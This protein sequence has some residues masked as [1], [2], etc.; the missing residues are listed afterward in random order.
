MT[1]P[2]HII[3]PGAIVPWQ[4][5]QRRRFASGATVTF[6]RP[7]VEAY[8]A[9]VRLAAERAMAER[10]PLDGPLELALLAV[11]AVPASWS[12]KRQR[13]ALAGLIAKTTKPDLENSIKGALDAMQSIVY[14]DDRQIISY[15]ACSKVYGERPRLEIVVTPITADARSVRVGR[16]LATEPDLFAGVAA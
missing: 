9:V 7:D 11:F 16:P 13:E 6:T 2:I 10:A 5:P 15:A 12:G 4:R 1:E 8:H 3:V 14:R